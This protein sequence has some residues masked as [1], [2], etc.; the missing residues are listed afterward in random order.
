M[1]EA[2]LLRALVDQGGPGGGGVPVVGW[3]S[4]SL[5]RLRSG[6]MCRCACRA[7]RSPS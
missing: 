6:L 7:S 5:S 3:C 4:G 2:A 1:L